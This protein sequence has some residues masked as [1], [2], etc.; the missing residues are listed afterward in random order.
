MTNGTRDPDL[1]AL[2]LPAEQQDAQLTALE[3]SP[4]GRHF[5]WLVDVVNEGYYADPGNGGNDGAASW[6]M[7][8]YEPRVPGYDPQRIAPADWSD[9]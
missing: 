4:L 8:G 5:A 6:A 3:R 2:Y 1:E 9:R 7:V